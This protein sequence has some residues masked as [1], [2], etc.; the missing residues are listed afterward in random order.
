MWANTMEPFMRFTV[1]EGDAENRI[2]VH[3]GLEVDPTS[4]PTNIP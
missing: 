3:H 4:Y 2:M 1:E